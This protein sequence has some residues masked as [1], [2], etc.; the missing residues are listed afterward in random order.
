VK[1]FNRAS[2]F[3]PTSLVLFSIVSTQLG[4]AIAKGFF[5]TLSPAAFALLRVAFAA[6]VLMVWWRPRIKN[7]LKRNAG[8]LFFFGL[9]LSLMN[10]SFY[11]AIAR[12]PLGIAVAIEFLGPLGVALFNSRQLLDFLWVALAG[13][14]IF[15][16]APFG[17][18][19]IDLT[20]IGLALV[21]GGFWAV[22]ILLSAKVGKTFLGGSGLAL[23]ITIGAISLAP[24][25]LLAGG[26]ALFQPQILLAGF[27][28]A[29]LSSVLPYSLELEALRSLPVRVFGVFMSLEP[30]VAAFISFVLLG[31]TL[32]LRALIAIILIS[33]AAAGVSL[34]GDRSL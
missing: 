14:G 23:A 33:V 16:L 17:E 30:V 31:E 34:F 26:A 2:T 21:A 22:Y 29:L 6:A 15:L 10:F 1:K 19:A 28:V 18:F 8:L 5:A 13:A 11:L 20:G 27:G 25:G 24:M 32:A 4:S 9:S 3:S 12:I 7:T